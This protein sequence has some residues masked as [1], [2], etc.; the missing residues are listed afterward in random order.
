MLLG[1]LL[2][3]GMELVAQE[4]KHSFAGVDARVFTGVKIGE[5]PIAGL[6]SE[7]LRAELNARSSVWL[8]A[9]MQL[10][11]GPEQ[12]LTTPR[13]LGAMHDPSQV[14]NE[15]L[16]WGRGEGLWTRMQQRLY[17]RRYGY[18]IPLRARINPKKTREVLEGLKERLRHDSTRARLDLKKRSFLPPTPA[19]GLLVEET[20]P[21]IAVGMAQGQSQ[22]ELAAYSMIPP[23]LAAQPRVFPNISTVIGE[24]SLP[25]DLSC[26]GE[27]ERKNNRRRAIERLDGSVLAPQERLSLWGSLG[28]PHKHSGFVPALACPPNAEA[29][30][31]DHGLSALAS[32]I[33]GAGFFA[34]MDLVHASL[35]ED[36]I[37]GAEL[38]L[39]AQL[40]WP[41]D[42]VELGNPHPFSLVLHVREE[43]GKIVAQWLGQARPFK[44]AF[45][46]EILSTK[47]FETSKRP[48]PKG[49]LGSETVLR[50]GRPGY[51][52]RRHR[53]WTEPGKEPRKESSLLNYPPRSAIVSVGEDPL[54]PPP[55]DDAKS[56]PKDRV[57]DPTV[58][59]TQ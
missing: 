6:D 56:E 48:D 7:N 46:R 53:I 24:Q 33:W 19:R 38:G 47:R 20:I 18:E 30:R 31:R 29:P 41:S 9:P 55:S 42:D 45:E 52:L 8:D 4:A 28:E 32:A 21:R 3:G 43:E 57:E 40:R 23:E 58:R 36:R 44:I 12:L 26:A 50:R 37:P 14:R 25:L 10:E 22:V 16:L 34:G 27:E 1:A 15:A 54:G 51:K 59:I 49:L 39:D 35:P 17:A 11:I 13:Q 5:E 2:L